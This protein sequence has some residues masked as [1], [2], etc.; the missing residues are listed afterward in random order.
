MAGL[1]PWLSFVLAVTAAA[2][3]PAPA[4]AARSVVDLA[5]LAARLEVGGE[6]PEVKPATMPPNFAAYAD[7]A[8][9]LTEKDLTWIL[10]EDSAVRFPVAL[11]VLFDGKATNA[12]ELLSQVRSCLIVAEAMRGGGD[13]AAALAR[14]A[15]WRGRAMAARLLREFPE[16]AA[17]GRALCLMGQLQADLPTEA[18]ILEGLRRLGAQATQGEWLLLAA[19]RLPA[20]DLDLVEQ[21]LANARAA[22]PPRLRETRAAVMERLAELRRGLAEA[23]RWQAKM[24]TDDL[25]GRLARLRFLQ[26]TDPRAALAFAKQL[27]EAKVEHALPWEVL[28]VAAMGMGD[29]AEARGRLDEARRHPHFGLLSAVD[30]WVLAAKELQ[31]SDTPERVRTRLAEVYRATEAELAADRSPEGLCIIK[32]LQIFDQRAS[33]DILDSLDMAAGVWAARPDSPDVYRILLGSALR[34]KDPVTAVA[35]VGRA[36]PEALATLPGIVLDRATVAVS[37]AIT[38]DREDATK[39]AAVC[40]EDL[41]RVQAD[42]ADAC[43]L[44]GLLA[45]SRGI[46]AGG[47]RGQLRNAGDLFAKAHRRPFERGAWQVA[48]AQYLAACAAGVAPDGSRIE[49][50][51]DCNPPGANAMA[52]FIASGL[53]SSNGK[54][55]AQLPQWVRAVDLPAA[56][57]VLA[58][59]EAMRRAELGQEAEVREAARRAL[60]ELDRQTDV[61]DL[62]ARGVFAIRAVNWRVTARISGPALPTSFHCD[63][64]PIPEL[65]SVERLRELAKD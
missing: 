38:T 8:R 16:D 51:L 47:D 63:L 29:P 64:F 40:C 13:G 11:R 6:T 22:V 21:T 2:Q 62:T 12:P 28:A 39:L 36:L 60:G 43:Y 55:L 54:T 59:A 65:P 3:D 7:R 58:S 41:E 49:E 52:P 42:A 15:T 45:W 27:T 26:A 32:L 4:A 5:Q 19:A 18:C 48:V 46:R 50:V 25:E 10:A 1:V 56:G 35:V 30:E 24:A 57:F 31:G 20:G 33:G 9:G 23:R 61:V 44:R 14:T 53:A 37:L 34:S 17:V